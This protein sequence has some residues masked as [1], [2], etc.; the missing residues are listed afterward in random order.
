MT[1]ATTQLR[2][3][4]PPAVWLL[5]PPRLFLTILALLGV[6]AF[7][8]AAAPAPLP[9]PLNLSAPALARTASTVLL[10]WDRPSDAV[11][12]YQVFC[13]GVFSGETTQLSFTVKFLPPDT[14]H[15]FTVR[16]RRQLGQFSEPC[17]PISIATKPAGTVLD[18]RLLGAA[19][20][21][22]TRDTAIIQRAINECP[23]NGTVLIPPG[24]YLV[25]HLDLKS[26]MTFDLAFGATLQFLGRGEGSYQARKEL[27]PGPDGAV[28]VPCGA[29]ITAQ[30]A[31]HLTITGGGLI[32]ANGETWWPRAK[33]FRPFVVEFVDCQD[34]FM[35][36][37]TIEDPPMWNTHV[38]YVD[39][40]V[41]SDLTFRKISLAH[42]TNGDGLNPDS[43]RD[44]LIVGCSFANQDDSIAIKAGKVLPDQPRRQRSCENITIRDCIVDGSLMPR[45]RPLGFAIGSESC[46]GIRHVVIRDCQFRNAAS[47]ANIKTNRERLGGLIED[48][49]IE[50]CVYLNTV[51]EDAPWNRAPIAVDA[52]YY[53]NV[54]SPDVAEPL[55]SQTPRIRNLYFKNIVIDSLP[56]RFMWLCGFRQLPFENIVF[57]NVSGRAKTGLH[58]QNIDGLR[59]DNVTITALAG[60][61]VTAINITNVTGSSVASLQR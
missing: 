52:Y 34:V 12:S 16:S 54:G 55:T 45:G 37:I 28:P 25:D 39:R 56:G 32:R 1:F 18:V 33:D 40:G 50:N 19:G 21:G 35:R 29:L 41:F 15:Q 42:G 36:G 14:K 44:I 30:R 4:P 58:L 49:H 31:H 53:E 8:R 20:D 3:L 6:P 51:F 47:L 26:D 9:A 13:D 48:I 7:A 23:V 5:A 60:P 22:R 61:P 11:T 17:A 24:V 59:F 43:A 10:L 57:E 2:V 27:L 46:G 38:L